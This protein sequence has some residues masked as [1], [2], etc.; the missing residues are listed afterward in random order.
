MKN[1]INIKSISLSIAL[2]FMNLFNSFSQDTTKSSTVFSGSAD[3]YY[4]Y[5]CSKFDNSKT[6]FTKSHDSFELGMASIKAAH[7][8][9]KASILVDLGFGNRAAEFTYNDTTATFMVKQLYVS[10]DFSTSFKVTAG[11]FATHLGYELIDAVDNKNY[12][13]SYAFTNGPFFNTGVKA[14]YT[15][16]KYNF[17]AGVTNPTDFKSASK[18][19][20]TQKTVIAQ[21]GYTG[22]TGNAYFNFTSGSLNPVSTANKTQFDIVASKK[23][24][25]KLSLGFNGTY[26]LTSDD[27]LNKTKSWYSVIGYANVT[28]KSNLSLAY[29]AEY[30]DDKDNVVGLAANVFANTLSLNYKEGNLTFIPEIRVDTAS[31]NIFTDGNPKKGT[32]YILIATT[33]AF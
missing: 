2:F 28:L 24:G 5:D 17:M 7:N 15:V 4:K 32:A 10:Y 29:R 21:V 9:G 30:F 22:K 27:L 26:A 16:G 8:S 25:E 3:M 11:S 13:M 18:A 33:Y 12:S 23:V 6:S 20:S 19:G 1:S 14:Q 31:E